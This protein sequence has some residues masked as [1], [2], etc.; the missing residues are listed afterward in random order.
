[1]NMNSIK[2][3]DIMREV[4]NWRNLS[5]TKRIKIIRKQKKMRIKENT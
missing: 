3:N 1:M 2:L 4:P 5:L